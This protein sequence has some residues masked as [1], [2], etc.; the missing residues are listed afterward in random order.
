MKQIRRRLVFYPQP[1]R[2][3]H[4]TFRGSIVVSIS[5]CHA[6]D[7]GSIPGRGVCRSAFRH[8]YGRSTKQLAQP[9]RTRALPREARVTWHLPRHGRRAITFLQV[10]ATPLFAA[11]AKRTASLGRVR[12][13][14]A[15]QTNAGDGGPALHDLR[16]GAYWSVLH[17]PKCNGA[18]TKGLQR[19]RYLMQ[20]VSRGAVTSARNDARGRATL[21]RARTFVSGTVGA[22]C[23][24]ASTADWRPQRRNRQHGRCG[25]PT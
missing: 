14:R 5:A 11:N 3:L 8:P 7:P 16:P 22:T 23:R 24:S 13:R 12:A 17:R 4:F 20:A 10:A 15:A 9:P 25:F 18:L 2:E 19:Q 1:L 6:E 21:G